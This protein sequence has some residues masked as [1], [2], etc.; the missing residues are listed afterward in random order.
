MK[1]RCLKE[2]FYRTG[3]YEAVTLRQQDMLSI[4]QWRNEQ[5]SVLRQSK[6]L[7]DED[8]QSYYQHVVRPSFEQE[9]PTIILFSFLLDGECIGY[10][11]LTN[12]DWMCKRAEISFL[13]N[14]NR[15]MDKAGYRNDFTAFLALMKKVAFEDLHFNRLFTET[16]D[17]RPHHVMI[18]EESGFQYE[19]RMRQHAVVDGKFV[20]S[21][22]HGCLK[23]FNHANR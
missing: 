22:L 3:G 17:I 2:S 15:I 18:L 4:K 13:L 19:G 23:E 12:N 20:D 8:Q 11:G 1:Y 21:L 14:T 7:T 6:V 9:H 16:Y 5:M 10:G